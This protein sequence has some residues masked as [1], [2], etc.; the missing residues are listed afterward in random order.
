MGLEELSLQPHPYSYGGPSKRHSDLSYA[1]MN[2]PYK[3]KDKQEGMPPAHQHP[4]LSAGT[5]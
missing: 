1:S 4:Q 3:G 2:V 5:F